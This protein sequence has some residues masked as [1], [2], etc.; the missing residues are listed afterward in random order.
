[1]SQVVAGED[2][3]SVPNDE[4]VEVVEAEEDRLYIYMTSLDTHACTCI[5]AGDYLLGI[6]KTFKSPCLGPKCEISSMSST[7]CMNGACTTMPEDRLILEEL[8]LLGED[9]GPRMQC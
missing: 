5:F 3:T 8:G 2:N 4:Y 9:M 7:T 1:M 6:T